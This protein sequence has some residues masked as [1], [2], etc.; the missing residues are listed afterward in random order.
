MYTKYALVLVDVSS[1]PAE[2]DF[3]EYIKKHP[4][5]I[6]MATMEYDD[7]I[8]QE[9]TSVLNALYLSLQRNRGLTGA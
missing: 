9:F 3:N 2:R 6:K 8:E 4:S 5:L 7:E 1:Y